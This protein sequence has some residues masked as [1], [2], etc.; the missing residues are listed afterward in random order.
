MA[1]LI[2]TPVATQIKPFPQ[3][4]LSDMLGIARTAQ[5]LKQAQIMN[6]LQ[7]QQAKELVKQSEISTKKA[8][9]AFSEDKM[10]KVSSS[11][12]SMINNPLV[13]AAERNP[14]SVDPVKLRDLVINNGMRTA[15]D[16][17]IPEDQAMQ[18]LQP[19]VE[20]AMNSPAGLRQYLKERH[21]QSLDDAARTELFE[22]RGQPISSGA[23]GY[24]VQTGEFGP[25]QPGQIIPGTAYRATLGPEQ[26]FGMGGTD[27]TGRPYFIQ[28]SP[29][30]EPMGMGQVPM[31]LPG[32]T[33]LPPTGGPAGA[34]AAAD[35]TRPYPP[36]PPVTGAMPNLG[37]PVPSN[38]PVFPS[39]AGGAAGVQASQSLF[40]SVGQAAATAP[41][42]RQ[43]SNKII[44]LADEAITG[45]GAQAIAALG[46]GYAALPFTSDATTN[47]QELGHYMA[48]QTAA[49]SQ[50]TGFSTTDAARGISEEMAGNV[51]WTAPAI[52]KTAR[53]NRALSAANELLYDGIRRAA[54]A[55]P[56]NPEVARQYRDQW[57]Q[58]MGTQGIDAI[59]LID[60]YQNRGDD[61]EGVQDIIKEFGGV[62]SEKFKAV[63]RKADELSKMMGQ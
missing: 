17:G 52:K 53:V 40:Q 42:E 3:T 18:L 50:S 62:K 8:E 48:L 19:Y 54:A 25:Y 5:E 49:L 16:L 4:S 10:K 2:G 15:K 24:T 27:I 46:G 47:L 22:P 33:G 45:K 7:A 58:S 38:A 29:T 9:T 32:V 43:N 12:I 51:Q 23:G 36:A 14:Q 34:P 37:A 35:G 44:K 39:A 1:D 31:G 6:P 13:L 63:M 30:G 61:P 20:Q 60:A 28:R 11:Q 26:Q 41:T 55:Q 56:N 59:R 57:A 21:I